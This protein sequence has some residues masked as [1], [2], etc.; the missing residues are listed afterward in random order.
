MT[1]PSEVTF[2]PTCRVNT[3]LED[4]LKKRELLREK[5]KGVDPGHLNI[6]FHLCQSYCTGSH[7]ILE[8]AFISRFLFVVCL[9]D[10][11]HCE[12]LRGSLIISTVK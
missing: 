8:D 5:G 9:F 6:L 12:I 1:P 11:F 4:L 7:P 3:K 2:L 10:A